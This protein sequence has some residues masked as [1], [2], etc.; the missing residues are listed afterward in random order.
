MGI[1]ALIGLV[2]VGY[3]V[4]CFVGGIFLAVLSIALPTK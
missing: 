2:V 3:F 1:L 4:F